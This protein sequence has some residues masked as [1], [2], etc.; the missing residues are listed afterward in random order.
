MKSMHKFFFNN[1]NNMKEISS[2]S[3][4]LVVT[5]PPYP[6]IELWDELFSTMNP[7]IKE[8]LKTHNGP[9]AFE[10][11]HQELDKVWKE[12]YRVLKKGGIACINVGDAVRTIGKDFR[13]YSNHSR[14]LN[15]CIKLGF[16]T[17]P[18]IIWRKPTNA[19][20]KFMGSGMLPP[21]AYITLE[22]EFIMILRKGGKR[23][24]KKTNE[25]S[26]R[27]ESAYF[28]EER[29]TWFSDLWFIKGTSQAVNSETRQRS[30]A[31]AYELAYRLI[32][33][34]SVKAD[35]VLDPFLG[36]GTTMLAAM[37]SERN[38]IGYELDPSFEKII[39][40]RI[41]NLVNHANDYL[42]DRLKKHESFVKDRLAQNKTLK[43][44]NKAH[45]VPVMTQQ[46]V[47]LVLNS[48]SRI[49]SK[50]ANCYEVSYL[51]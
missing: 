14:I 19:P 40:R 48:L 4:D 2:K 36:T 15:Y 49:E 29:N 27:Q 50:D 45:N 3:I 28:W 25:K 7:E 37:S 24:F 18:E 43:Y 35:I 23:E 26:I 1:S 31:F 46:E 51:Q 5:S 6:I 38:S 30:A 13:L 9:L 11:M 20:N 22:H 8:A 42:K 32:N 21:S 44:I 39:T 12:V 41:D 34:F 17:L 33:M 16:N 10:L 47:N